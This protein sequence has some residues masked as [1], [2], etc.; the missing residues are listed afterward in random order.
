MENK[1]THHSEHAVYNADEHQSSDG[2]NQDLPLPPNLKSTVPQWK[3]L[4]KEADWT[5]RESWSDD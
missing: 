2:E 4:N 1:D 5:E 3:D